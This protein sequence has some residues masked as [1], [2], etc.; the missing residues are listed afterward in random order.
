MSGIY[1]L[2]STRDRQIV[3]VGLTVANREYQHR[4]HETQP[5]LKKWLQLERHFGFDL[6]FNVL[7]GNC[8][9]LNSR[10]TYWCDRIRPKLN[11]RKNWWKNLPEGTKIIGPNLSH[12]EQ[13]ML[14]EMRRGGLGGFVENWLGYIGVRYHPDTETCTVNVQSRTGYIPLY[15]DGGSISQRT[16]T[17]R[18]RFGH[19]YYS[20]NWHFRNYDRAIEERERFR[21]SHLPI[22]G[23]W[24]K[25]DP[26]LQRDFRDDISRVPISYLLKN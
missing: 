13:I 11:I 24:P 17:Y 7:E 21:L 19:V 22:L 8:T 18:G 16:R 23:F 12:E 1:G 9:D 25:D 14:S 6:V 5:Q 20:G 10:E 3:Y 26:R 2:S 4:Y 15:G